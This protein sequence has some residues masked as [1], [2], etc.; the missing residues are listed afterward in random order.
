MYL[1]ILVHAPSG[2]GKTRFIGTA[3][4]DARFMPGLLCDFEGGYTTIRS[5]VETVELDKLATIKQPSTSKLTHVRIKSWRDIDEVYDVLTAPDCPFRFVAFDSLS[6]IH[7]LSLAEVVYAAYKKAPTQHDPDL[8]NQQDFGKSLAQMRKFIRY[9]RDLD[10]MHV[11]FTATT[12]D[13]EDARTR[14]GQARPNLIGKLSS[15][16]PALVDFVGYLA[17]RDLEGGGTMRVLCTGPSE[18][19]I[20]KARNDEDTLAQLP[21]FMDDPTLPAVLSALYGEPTQGE[22]RP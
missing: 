9:F 14:R 7:Y 2:H 19:Y 8:A 12:M 10:G 22:A 16:A 3:T 20:A 21:E 15:E 11:L 5:R 6:E 17:I 4:Q 18:R 13:I 1:K